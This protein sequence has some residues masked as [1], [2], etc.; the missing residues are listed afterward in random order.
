[1]R[2][3]NSACE[4]SGTV[5]STGVT[6]SDQHGTLTDQVRASWTGYT[7]AGGDSGAP[8]FSP[9]TT[10]VSFYGIL[11][12]NYKIGSTPYGVYSPWQHI[13]SELNLTP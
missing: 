1:M 2:T 10:N 6:V 7:T 9:R 3:N 13:K 8:V 12:G 4:I 11:V 5:V